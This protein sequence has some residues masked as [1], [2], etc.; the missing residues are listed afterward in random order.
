[1]DLYYIS[2]ALKCKYVGVTD[3]RKVLAVVWQD[4]LDLTAHPPYFQQRP[5]F[6]LCYRIV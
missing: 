6:L 2:Y 4:L 3:D 5:T 1:M